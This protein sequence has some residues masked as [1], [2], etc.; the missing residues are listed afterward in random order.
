MNAFVNYIIESGLSL[1]I[2]ILIYWFVLRGETK[3]KATRFY[4]ILALLFSTLLPLLTIRVGLLSSELQSGIPADASQT[5]LLNSITVYASSLPSKVGTAILSFDYSV[6]LYTLGAVGAVFVIV[7]GILQLLLAMT[8]NRVYK[9]NKAFLVVSEK[10]QSPYSFFNYIFI[11]KALTEEKNW[12]TMV[13]HE[14]E[15]VKQGH[16]FDV[17][18]VDFMM[19]FQWFNPFYWVLRR[20][21]REN[22]EF[23]ADTGVLQRGL[24]SN[25]RYKEL[26]LAQAI[27][28]SPVITSNFFNIK[29]IKKRFK[30]IT[31]KKTKKYSVLR[32]TTGVVMALA[33]TLLFACEDF[34]KSLIEGKGSNY[35]YLGEMTTLS[36]IQTQG[37]KNISI[38]ES[39]YLDV[40]TVYPE[41]KGKVKEDVAY[42]LAF[43]T[44]DKAQAGLL[45]KLTIHNARKAGNDVDDIVVIGN[46]S[47]KSAEL[48]GEIFI[49]VEEM[50]EFPGGEM[51]LRKFIATQVKYPAVAAE[52][53]IQGKVYVTFVVDKEGDVRN[54]K[55]ARGVDP[56]L[57]AE[58]LRVVS[59]IPKW[60][61]GKQRGQAVN[62]SYT[63]P[64]NFALQ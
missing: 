56:S 3:F 59:S 29:T 62:V 10:E 18:F 42:Y 4:L 21:I 48:D 23:L 1:G 63:V 55:I 32:Y 52:Q 22:H 15:H 20:L 17:L 57:D 44:E 50:P 30:M 61:P 45:N 47:E 31:N 33:L 37:I 24:I 39:D 12:K 25:A 64:I 49:I 14:V 26:L 36:E 35:I 53:G 43:N 7:M 8:R 27:G 46:G 60:I 19:V 41:L 13:Y 51:E 9:L 40:L 28:G 2:F 34:D 58:A 38:V 6:L 5:N 11:G 54:A 16:S